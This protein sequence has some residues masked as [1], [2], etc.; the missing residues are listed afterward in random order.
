[1]SKLGLAMLVEDVGKI[2]VRAA[3]LGLQ[4]VDAHSLCIGSNDGELKKKIFFLNY[5]LFCKS[6]TSLDVPF[7]RIKAQT[8]SPY[9]GSGTPTTEAL[10]T[11]EC[12]NKTS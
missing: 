11:L 5:H 3:G 12:S 2:I 7:V 9:L 1:V 8:V 10:R 6:H 4:A